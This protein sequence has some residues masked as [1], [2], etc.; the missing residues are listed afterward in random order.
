VS[1]KI[2][3]KN[4]KAKFEYEFLETFTAGIQLSGTEIKSIRAGKANIADGYCFFYNDEL[5]VKNVFIAEY[6]QGTYNNHE[7]RRVRKLLLNRSELDKLIKKK[8]DVGLT[9][10]PVSLFINNKGFAKLEIAL[11]KGKKL[12]DKRETLKAKDT[13]RELDRA[14]KF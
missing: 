5:F 12:H 7:P 3:I 4:R 8:K 11:A 13:K 9:I 6:E 2:N 10:V 1:N 14:K